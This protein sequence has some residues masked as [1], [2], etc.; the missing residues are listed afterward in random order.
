M[1][2]TPFISDVIDGIKDALK[3]ILD[4]GFT[5]F[6]QI[7]YWLKDVFKFI[8]ANFRYDNDAHLFTLSLFLFIQVIVLVALF[9][10]GSGGAGGGPGSKD[11]GI[12]SGYVMADTSGGGGTVFINSSG[13]VVSNSSNGA[14]GNNSQ[15]INPSEEFCG[16]A[17]CDNFITASNFVV[18]SEVYSFCSDQYLFYDIPSY[19]Q[20]ADGLDTITDSNTG[21]VYFNAVCGTLNAEQRLNPRCVVDSVNHWIYYVENKANCPI[22]CDTLDCSYVDYTC[23]VTNSCPY[24]FCCPAG[25][26]HAGKCTDSDPSTS[27]VCDDPGTLGLLPTFAVNMTLPESSPGSVSL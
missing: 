21:R 24:A 3:F 12:G 20:P 19:C 13:G 27:G 18:L 6:K 7:G 22:D 5:I 16:N 26:Y 15:T 11:I 4:S 1:G 10:G 9:G 23:D 25:S 2:G 17:V 8:F 14:P